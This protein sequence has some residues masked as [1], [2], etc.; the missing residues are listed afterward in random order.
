MD[1]E[2]S[3][4]RKRSRIFPIPV[5]FRQ[6]VFMVGIVSCSTQILCLNRA[7]NR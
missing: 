1:G 5:G 3:A 6:I 4:T 2:P 7:W